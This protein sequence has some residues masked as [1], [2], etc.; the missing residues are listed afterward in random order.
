MKKKLL[1][2]AL[3]VVSV[4]VFSCKKGT[5]QDQKA[6]VI[7]EESQPV[8]WLNGTYV[9]QQEDALLKEIVLCDEG[10]ASVSSVSR[11]Y[12][13]AIE[14]GKTKITVSSNGNFAFYVS[15]DKTTL[16]PA[17][18]FTKEWGTNAVFLLD[19]EKEQN[20]K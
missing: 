16:T 9:N 14:K 20:C 12:T 2:S 8:A 4:F 19:K 7:A 13:I 5:G 11:T 3:M 10:K 15:E 17:D 6:E 1:I 18:A